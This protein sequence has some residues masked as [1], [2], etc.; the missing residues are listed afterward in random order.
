MGAGE[1]AYLLLAIGAALSFMA[2]L[3]FCNSGNS[4]NR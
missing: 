3:A 1:I 4:K 2:V